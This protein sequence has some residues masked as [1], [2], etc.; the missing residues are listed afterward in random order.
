M[1]AKIHHQHR[2]A[3]V[4]SDAL[5]RTCTGSSLRT[6]GIDHHSFEHLYGLIHAAREGGRFDAIL[7][8]LHADAAQQMALMADVW[9]ALGR[10][11]GLFFL[12]HPTEL[13]LAQLALSQAGEGE[14]RSE[15]I[16]SPASDDELRAMFHEGG[17]TH[18]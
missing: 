12:A 1:T 5:Q 10:R 18:A 6:A 14:G 3:L 15:V 13:R 4:D 2:V 9:S 7:F 17:V 8:G 16:L 11:V